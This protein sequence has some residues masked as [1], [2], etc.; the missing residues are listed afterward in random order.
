MALSLLPDEMAALEP[1]VYRLTGVRWRD[2]RAGNVT[3]R[4]INHKPG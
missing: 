3:V 4:V 2:L 1:G